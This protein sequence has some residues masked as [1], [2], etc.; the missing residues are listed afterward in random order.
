[1]MKWI[2]EEKNSLIVSLIVITLLSFLVHIRFN[3]MNLEIFLLW[4]P[5][6]WLLMLVFMF[7]SKI[8]LGGIKK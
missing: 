2:K 1:M 5:V 3:R 6:V 8:I 7:G 4:L